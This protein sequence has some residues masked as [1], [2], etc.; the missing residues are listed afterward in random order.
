ME[1]QKLEDEKNIKNF[2]QFC[3][4]TFKRRRRRTQKFWKCKKQFWKTKRDFD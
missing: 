1:K 4:T 2:S 3:K